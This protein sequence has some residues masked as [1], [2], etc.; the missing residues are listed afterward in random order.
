MDIAS[1]DSKPKKKVEDL[2]ILEA[3]TGSSPDPEN[4][5]ILIGN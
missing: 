3:Q 1:Y 5:I 4:M 2:R